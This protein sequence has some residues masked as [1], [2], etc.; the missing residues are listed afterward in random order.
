M[1]IRINKG[2]QNLDQPPDAKYVQTSLCAN[3][4]PKYS[5]ATIFTP[6]CEKHILTRPTEVSRH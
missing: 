6:K 1:V 2:K 3:C 4:W 5:G